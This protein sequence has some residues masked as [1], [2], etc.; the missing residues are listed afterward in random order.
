MAPIGKVS[1][2]A[3]V[4]RGAGP[5]GADGCLGHQ[6][7]VST[8]AHPAAIAIKHQVQ[9]N[10]GRGGHGWSAGSSGVS[11]SAG[12]ASMPRLISVAL[13]SKPTRANARKKPATI[14]IV[15]TSAVRRGGAPS[16]ARAP[17]NATRAAMAATTHT[18]IC[19][20]RSYWLAR[21]PYVSGAAGVIGV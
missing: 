3:R 7:P 11:F 16:S 6:I 17:M 13:H 4:A 5:A 14:A 19:T 20:R 12:S 15:K 8:M 10:S 2:S 9:K 21:S 18:A 1:S